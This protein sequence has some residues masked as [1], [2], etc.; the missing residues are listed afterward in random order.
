MRELYGLVGRKLGHSFSKAYFTER[1]SREGRDAEYINI[2]IGSI[3]ELPAIIAGHTELCGLNVTIPY[4]LDVMGL[5]DGLSP[6]AEAIGAVN[7]IQF[8]RNGG[9]GRTQLIGHNTDV[10]GFRETLRPLLETT[11]ITGNR[12]YILGTGGASRAVAHGLRQLGLEPEFVSRSAGGHLIY[13]DLNPER[14]SEA[15]VIVNTTPLGMWPDVDSCPPIA[16]DA[17]H[18]GQICYDLVYNPDPTLFMRKSQAQGATVLS[19][20]PMLERQAEESWL[21]W[22]G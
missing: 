14:L 21:I 6:E 7:V 13:A 19:G 22:Q 15:A 17:L 4:K 8:V 3:D 1:F 11:G 10:I 2:E 16:Y 5:L 20:R 9:G 18:S 12:A